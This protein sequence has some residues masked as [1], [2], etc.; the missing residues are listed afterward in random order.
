MCYS[1]RKDENCDGDIIIHYIVFVSLL[2]LADPAAMR[3]AQGCI[4]HHNYVG[5][6]TSR[7]AGFFGLSGPTIASFPK[8]TNVLPQ[9]GSVAN[10]T[11]ANFFVFII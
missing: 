7:W 11:N 5:R 6:V 1:S 8:N 2:Q 9:C 10:Q 3:T 4:M